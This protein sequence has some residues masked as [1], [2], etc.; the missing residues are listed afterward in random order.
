MKAYIGAFRKKNGEVR[1]MTFVKLDDLPNSFLDSQITGTGKARRL[2]EGMET[3]W[4]LEED[5]F[6][7]FNFASMVGDIEEKEIDELQ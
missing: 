4:D 2:G 6:R 3:V 5:A 1:R 7:T